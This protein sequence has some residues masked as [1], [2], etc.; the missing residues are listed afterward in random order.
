MNVVNIH[1]LYYMAVYG[2]SK[3]LDALEANAPLQIDRKYYKPKVINGI[4]KK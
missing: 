2:G 1:D 4:V 3:T